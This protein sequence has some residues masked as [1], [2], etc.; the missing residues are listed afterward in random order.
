MSFKV[1]IRVC[2]MK[3][4]Y[5]PVCQGWIPCC[6]CARDMCSF[7][8]FHFF[9]FILL[10]HKDKAPQQHVPITVDPYW[11]DIS[12]SNTTPD[13]FPVSRQGKVLSVAI[14]N[15]PQAFCVVCVVLYIM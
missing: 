9:H 3:D 13:L 2:T 11:L 14:F 8:L 1:K 12:T 10:H 15:G 7:L 4:D 5:S 6:C